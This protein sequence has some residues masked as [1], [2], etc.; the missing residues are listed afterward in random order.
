VEVKVNLH[1][2]FRV[3]I[4]PSPLYDSLY[5]YKTLG[6]NSEE[7]IP[8][9]KPIYIITNG[10]ISVCPTLSQTADCRTNWKKEKLFHFRRKP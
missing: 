4:V 3:A 2:F 7:K 5:P 8:L 1:S 6:G 9:E 10:G